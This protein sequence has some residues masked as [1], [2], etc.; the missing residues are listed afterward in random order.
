MTRRAALLGGL[1]ALAL[2][3]HARP[4]MAQSNPQPGAPARAVVFDTDV[5][6]DD[7]VALAA[8]AQQ[9]LDG[10][11]DL[12]AVTIT[13]D[14]AGLPGKAYLHARCLLDMLGLPDVPVA[15]T[16]YN[17][18]HQFPARL[19]FAID[20][21]LDSSIPDCAAG[22]VPAPVS[23]GQL[24]GDTVGNADGRL[25][26]IA[27]GPL[28]NVA[29]GM[30]LLEARY[31]EGATAL[32]NRAYIEGG[33]V[34]VPGGLEGVPGFDDT[35]NINTWG[36]PA[37]A[38]TVFA[39][40]RTGSVFLVPG[41]ATRFVPVHLPYLAT[42]AADART[43]AARYVA[44]MMSH[45]ILVGAIDAGLTVDWWDPLA[46]LSATTHHLV[47]F[48]WTRIEV[49]Q[50]GVSSGRTLESPSGTL[51]RVGFSADT[52]LFERTLLDVLNGVDRHP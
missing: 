29:V 5:D 12:R 4:A 10:R 37:A 3:G 16:T 15:D 35:Q 20:I 38:Q 51:M 34:R 19:R 1:V 50:D 6:F 40:L 23:A 9:H 47:S 48:E 42:L 24:L 26:L 13:N 44:T 41:D 39:G 14:G 33:A 25:T 11:I 46:A 30:Q 8:L 2:A 18:P 49:I 22:H 52:A 27:T 36:D 31:G 45:P 21:V 7:T 43:P 32:I 28:T 17:L